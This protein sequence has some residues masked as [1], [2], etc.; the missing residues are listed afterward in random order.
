MTHQLSEA[1]NG[2]IVSAK[3]GDLIALCLR[4]KPSG[5]YR[6][7]VEDEPGDV[8]EKVEQTFDF[9]EGSVGGGNETRLLFRVKAAGTGVLRLCYDRPWQT[10]E[11]PLKTWQVTVEAK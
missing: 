2:T 11:P 8:L 5:G 3:A 1:D 10:G 4:G 9:A 7:T 6:W